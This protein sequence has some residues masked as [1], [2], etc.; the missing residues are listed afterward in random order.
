MQMPIDYKCTCEDQSKKHE[1]ECPI[2]IF[3]N[4]NK[5]SIKEFNKRNRII[6]RRR[7]YGVSSI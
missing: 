4:E 6:T 3:Q 2:F 5:E 7:V 1:E